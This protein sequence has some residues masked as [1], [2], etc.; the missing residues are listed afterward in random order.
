MHDNNNIWEDT[1]IC[2]IMCECEAG[3]GVCVRFPVAGPGLGVGR[4]CDCLDA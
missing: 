2:D 3:E 1:R 4:D